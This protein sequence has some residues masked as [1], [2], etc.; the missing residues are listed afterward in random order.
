MSDLFK[1]IITYNGFRSI[2]VAFQLSKEQGRPLDYNQSYHRN[3]VWTD[4]KSTNLIETVLLYGEVPPIVVYEKGDDSEKLRVID[5]KQRCLAIVRFLNDNFRLKQQGLDKLWKLA[6]KK[7]SQLDDELKERIQNTML[8]F[9]TI[10]ITNEKDMTP[11]AEKLLIRELFRR[12]NLGMSPL[13]KEEVSKAQYL[14][15][16]INI[17]FLQRFKQET[18]L[19]DRV[20]DIFNHKSRSIETMMQHIRQLLVLHN[21]PISRYTSERDDIV[22]KYYDFLSYKI[23]NN[24]DKECIPQI[25][26]SFVEKLSFLQEIKSRLNKELVTSNGLVYDCI[27]WA[28]SICEKENGD[29]NKINNINFIDRLVDHIVKRQQN[30]VIEKNNY[31]QLVKRRYELIATFFCSQLPI[32]FSNYLQSDKEFLLTHKELLNLYFQEDQSEIERNPLTRSLPTS[33]PV[34][35]FIDKMKRNKY[36]LRPPYQRE[37][38]MSIPIASSLIESILLGIKFYPIYVY[39]NKNGISEVIDGQQRLLAI[40]GFLGKA[41][42]NED[43][44]M[45]FSKKNNFSLNLKSPLIPN[46]SKKKFSELPDVLQK[47]I[48]NFEINVIEIVEGEYKNFKPEDLFKRFNH[49]PS[50]IKKDTFEFWNA[51]IDRDIINAIK[52]FYQRNGWLYLRKKDTRMNNESLITGLCYLDYVCKGIPD[53]SVV[54][55]V[56]SISSFRS[57]IT[58]KLK[59]K[60]YVTEVLQDTA[61]KDEFLLSLNSFESSFLE[62]LKTLTASPTGNTT[63]SFRNK[64]LDSILQVQNARVAANFYVLWLILKGLPN[65]FIRKSRSIVRS[66]ISKVFSVLRTGTSVEKFEAEIIDTWNIVD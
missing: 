48:Y 24:G 28:L 26:D 66:R 43:G 52:D 4:S 23:I 14:Q 7:F 59:N 61:F 31:A 37:E 64:Q 65:E 32:N 1:N 40:L 34:I 18:T 53:I 54:K 11:A 36:R 55:E 20:N 29:L 5:G 12:Y 42:K 27:Y 21:I 60:S 50:P 30:Y 51:C 16:E 22:N 56:L 19:C 38:A 2:R 49:K 46:L 8:R 39:T 44:N 35:D 57:S 63:E 58:V 13:K 45:E 10:K 15:N 17:Y 47:R 3:W 25:F 9:I 41:Y 62:K 6:G 33:M